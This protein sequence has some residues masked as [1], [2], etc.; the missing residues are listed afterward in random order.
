MIKDFVTKLNLS[1]F[2]KL[3]KSRDRTSVVIIYILLPAIIILPLLHIYPSED[4]FFYI[5]G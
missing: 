3:L 5:N 1:S 4:S 2:Y